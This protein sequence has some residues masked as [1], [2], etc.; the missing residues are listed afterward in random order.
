[1]NKNAQRRRDDLI[2][3]F[4][5][6]EAWLTGFIATQLAAAKLGSVRE[7]RRASARVKA[8]LDALRDLTIPKI[9][10]LIKAGYL[11]GRESSGAPNLPLSATDNEAIRLLVENLSGRLEDGITTVGRRIDDIFRREGLRAVAESLAKEATSSAPRDK[12]VNR[13]QREGVSA[14]TDSLGRRYRLETYAQMHVK[15]VTAEAENHGARNLILS[16]DFDVVTIGHPGH[17]RHHP[18]C[19]DHHGKKFSLTGRSDYPVLH[20]DDI[21]P[22]HPNCEHFIK[23][24]PEAVAERRR[25]AKASKRKRARSKSPVPA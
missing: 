22:Y 2:R 4:Q 13:L 15:T 8:A 17:Y 19:D 11:S 3:D 18:K 20:A 12:M 7:R 6:I 9:E 21:P 1:M 24:A 5:R 23:L 10:Q 16:R 14:F 25:A